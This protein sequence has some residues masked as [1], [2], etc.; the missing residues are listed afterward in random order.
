[1]EIEEIKWQI[2]DILSNHDIGILTTDEML[3]QIQTQVQRI[4]TVLVEES[5]YQDLPF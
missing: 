1:M 4:K 5:I 2:R 3:E